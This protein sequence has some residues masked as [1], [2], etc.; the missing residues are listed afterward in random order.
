MHFGP[1]LQSRQLGV[2][3]SC[4]LRCPSGLNGASY[5]GLAFTSYQAVPVSE[6]QGEG[7]DGG[8]D[9]KFLKARLSMFL[10]IEW[11]ERVAGIAQGR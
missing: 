5:L 6:G 9:V 7:N 2:G 1:L 4:W 3:K 8:C 10:E 11:P